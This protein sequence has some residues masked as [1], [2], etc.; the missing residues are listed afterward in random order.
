MR[1]NQIPRNTAAPRPIMSTSVSSMVGT[2]VPALLLLIASTPPVVADEMA[3][4]LVVNADIHTMNPEQPRAGALAWSARG[5]LLAVGET[6]AL[7][8]RFPDAPVTNLDGKTVI[9][10]LIDAHG[11]VMGLGQAMLNADLAGAA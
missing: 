4:G 9:P 1:L 7:R 10:G 6:D 5:R 3:A 2:L 8:Q 11:H